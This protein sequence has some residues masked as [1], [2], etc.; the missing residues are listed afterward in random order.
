[1][2]VSTSRLLIA[3]ND[4]LST[5]DVCVFIHSR[6]RSLVR[7]TGVLPPRANCPYFLI[8]PPSLLVRVVLAGEQR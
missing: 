6:V 4:T 5:E 7:H 1:M 3:C 8:N 2:T